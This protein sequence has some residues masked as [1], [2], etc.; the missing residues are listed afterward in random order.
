MV[1]NYL[2]K[3]RRLILHPEE[4]KLLTSMRMQLKSAPSLTEHIKEI[5]LLV[6]SKDGFVF[7]ERIYDE[8]DK[9]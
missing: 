5:S 6:K 4:V 9:K 7:N 2:F 3:Q 8:R 1:F